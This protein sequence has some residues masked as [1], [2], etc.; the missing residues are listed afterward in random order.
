MN[1]GAL[2]SA[3]PPEVLRP[4]EHVR[5]GDAR[6]VSSESHF[7]A[8][9]AVR[10]RQVRPTDP[11]RR[12]RM[13]YEASV[14]ISWRNTAGGEISLPNGVQARSRCFVLIDSPVTSRCGIQSHTSMRTYSENSLLTTGF[15]S[16]YPTHLFQMCSHLRSGALERDK[17]REKTR[18]KK[19][20]EKRSG[21]NRAD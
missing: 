17:K 20:R 12:R 6:N 4:G 14:P 7:L 1:D 8:S 16:S 18:W 13:K 10:R 19:T 3:T 15:N 21:A 11:W 9:L 2:G 5:Y